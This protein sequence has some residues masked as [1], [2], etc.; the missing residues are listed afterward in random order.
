[1]AKCDLDRPILYGEV[2]IPGPIAFGHECVAEVVETGGEA[3][4]K[5]RERR[6]S[7]PRPPA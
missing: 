1:V 6:D 5:G 3:E 4:F 7:N 2:P